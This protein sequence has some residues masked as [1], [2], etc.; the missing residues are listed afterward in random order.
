MNGTDFRRRFALTLGLAFTLTLATAAVAFAAG[1]FDG[2][3]QGS[4][5]VP[6][7]ALEIDVDLATAE[8]GTLSGDISI[9]IQGLRDFALSGIE[10][11]LEADP[12]TIRFEMA[13]IPGM[14]T[15]EGTL[16]GDGK[17]LSG[18]FHQG[19]A[20]LPFELTT[21]GLSPADEAREALA[22]FGELA[23]QAVADFNV[24]GAGIAVVAGGEVVYA[25]GFGHRDVEQGLPMTA[26]SLFAI[27]S[28]TKAM[29]ATLLGML[30]DEGKLEWD[31][32]LTQYL[33]GFRL[34]DPMV[35]ARITPRDLV[36]HRSGLPRHDLLWYNN[37]GVSRREVIERLAHLELTAD[38]RERFQYN[39]LMF[40]T[41]GYLAGTLEGSTWEEAIRS[42]LFEPLG[43]ERTNL[44]VAASETDPDHALPYREEDEEEDDTLE[45]IPFRTIDLVGPAGSVNSTVR[46]MA[47]WLLFNLNR[48]RVGET[49]LVNP[50]TL[51]DIQSPHMTLPGAPTPDSRV[52]QRDYGMGWMVEVYRGHRRLQHGGGIDGFTTSVMLYPD[53]GVGVVAF[54]NRGSGLPNLLA[55]EA[56][57]R[58]LG[59]EPVDWL[60][61]ALTRLDAAEKVA[62]EAES[63]KEA[64]RVADTTPSH[65]MADYLGSYEHP[66]YGV[67]TIT[68][69]DGGETG[70]DR[71]LALTF[72]GITA[73]LEHWHYDVWNGAETDGD[74]TF[75]GTKLLFRTDFEGQI[76]EV[77]APFELTASPIV[78]TKQ[79]DPR[80][81]DPKYLDRL[82]GTYEG[83]TGQRGRIERSGDTLTLNLPGQPTFTLVPQ[84]SGR[85][86]LEGLEGFSIDFVEE[87]GKIT[88]VVYYQ[89]NGVFEARRVED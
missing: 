21:G 72:N 84:V 69:G 74:P 54:S 7:Q 70:E 43:M 39:N 87:K 16:S 6:G 66:G 59:L 19:G 3:W 78:F 4:I 40:M 35:T 61:E 89:P 46:E 41:A 65:P 18:T 25:E 13:G 23:E 82:V 37:N 2:H 62:E 73:P 27:G 83:A 52:S 5:Q 80:L 63:K 85:F 12:A 53:D 36:T 76:T 8:D 45:R 9:P 10:A 86:G 68:A 38:L 60:G 48:G 49:Q 64:L 20:A 57:D 77:E 30:V 31:E 55:Q 29:T 56:A 47:S 32:P 67:L 26:D 14:P 24:P 15:F 50:A 75:E 33:P 17:T 44:S 71:A 28:T 22:G 42:R 34:S 88:K 79:P 51:A 11:D 58:V 1:P 81:S